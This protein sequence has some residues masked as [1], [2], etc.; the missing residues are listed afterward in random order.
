MTNEE[1][2][3]EHIL[4]KY[5]SIRQ[6][7]LQNDFPYSTVDSVFKRG[8]DGCSVSLAIKI[9]DKLGICVDDL[10]EGKIV[11]KNIDNDFTEKEKRIVLAYRAMPEMQ[12]A[13]DKLLDIPVASEITVY[14]AAHSD[15]N[16]DDEITKMSA[17]RLQKL[18][19]A[20][21]TDKKL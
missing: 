1:I 7:C 12:P 4:S 10:L 2:L 5:K 20:P 11:L 15:D 13:I 21:K 17:E 8:L 3:K 14:R 6:F 19:D 9:C 18:K 16:H